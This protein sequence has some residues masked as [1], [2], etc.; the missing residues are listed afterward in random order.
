MD[1]CRSRGVDWPG[2]TSSF[3]LCYYTTGEESDVL[4]RSASPTCLCNADGESSGDLILPAPPVHLVPG[5][6]TPLPTIQGRVHQR[7]LKYH[8]SDFPVLEGMLE[9]PEVGD[10]DAYAVDT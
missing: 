10:S 4:W 8:Q 2:C 9:V 7:L 6:L 1:Y 3:F 5:D